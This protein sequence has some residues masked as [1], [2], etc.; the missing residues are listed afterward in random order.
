MSK[1]NELFL[2]LYRTYEGLLRARGVDYRIIEDEQIK[3]GGSRMTIMRQMRNYLAHS[4]DPGFITISP[5]CVKVLEK[6]VKEEQM[7][8]DIVK[9]HLITPAKGSI[10]EGTLLSEAVYQ[11]SILAV[12]GQ[13]EIP[14]YHPSTKRLKG[15]AKLEK[16]AY[17]LNKQG[18]VPLEEKTYGP[19][20]KSF[21]LVKPD[22]LTPTKADDR[23]YCC[24]KD[25]TINSQYMGYLDK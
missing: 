13:L 8:G 16:L 1:E 20:D 10:K 14:V 6:M 17:E 25:G 2:S 4:E 23:F 5:V 18:N 3:Q 22:E 21:I 12:K 11:L 19:Y 24:T 7:K 9:N 15:I